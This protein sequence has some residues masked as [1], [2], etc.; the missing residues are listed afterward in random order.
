MVSLIKLERFNDA[1]KVAESHE[2]LLEHVYSLYR[3]GK[4]D[5]ALKAIGIP[6]N[7]TESAMAVHLLHLK[8][9][10]LNRLGR[11]NECLETVYPILMTLYSKTD[12]ELDVLLNAYAV[13]AGHSLFSNGMNLDSPLKAPLHQLDASYDHLFNKSCVAIA[14]KDYSGAE[15]LLAESRRLCLASQQEDEG[16]TQKEL[17]AIAVQLGY[18]YQVQH[19]HALAIQQYREGLSNK[20]ADAVTCAIASN[21]LASLQPSNATALKSFKTQTIS[22]AVVTKLVPMQKASLQLNHVLLLLHLGKTKEAAD[23]FNLFG[24]EGSSDPLL[25]LVALYLE[26]AV[27]QPEEFLKEL[28]QLADEYPDF[29]AARL[30]RIQVAIDQHKWEEAAGLVKLLM[31]SQQSSQILPGLLSVLPWLYGQLGDSASALQVLEEATRT[32]AGSTS[33]QLRK[34]LALFKFDA[35]RFDEAAS[36]YEALVQIDSTDVQSIAGL[37]VSYSKLDVGKAEKYLSYLPVDEDVVRSMVG[38]FSDADLVELE[39]AVVKRRTVVSGNDE[40]SKTKR[41][42]RRKLLPENYDPS[43]PP[44]PNRWVS[45]KQQKMAAM[46]KKGKFKRD[47]VKGSQGVNLEGGGIGG[48]GSSNIAGITGKK[49]T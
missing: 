46:A 39:E 43:I 45:K 40:T 1:V 4:S 16:D 2:T 14:Q 33:T 32:G 21:N 25:R 11:F 42:K 6:E 3:L 23:Q 18:V 49:S 13:F 30:T 24:A 19:R 41:R 7:N 17:A 29:L 36:E 47:L 27:N 12:D 8:A 9:Q 48:T 37:V 44:D 26:K 20:H 35:G 15:M 5:E 22:N 10:I 38:K 31:T 34:Q 28:D